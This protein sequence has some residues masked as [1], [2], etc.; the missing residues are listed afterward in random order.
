MIRAIIYNVIGVLAVLAVIFFKIP[1]IWV[2]LGVLVLL[3]FAIFNPFM[4][5]VESI[6][7]GFT[8]KKAKTGK[9]TLNYIEG[10][11]NGPPLLFMRWSPKFRQVVKSGF[12]S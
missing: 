10:P 3:A 12:C 11:D 9:V 4:P 7:K 2:I 5:S 8:E 6:P 1:I